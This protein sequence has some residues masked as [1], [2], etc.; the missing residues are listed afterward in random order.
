MIPQFRH[1][2]PVLDESP[3]G[4]LLGLANLFRR[5]SRQSLC[6]GSLLCFCCARRRSRFCLAAVSFGG[7]TLGVGACSSL[8]LCGSELLFQRGH[9]P[10]AVGLEALGS[11]SDRVAPSKRP[12]SLRQR[13]GAW[14]GGP[15]HKHGNDALAFLERSPDFNRNKVVRVIGTRGK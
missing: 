3:V 6:P 2:S 4:K 11:Q 5:Q 13:F 15:A 10:L 8:S 7:G 12:N 1:V 14:D 9:E